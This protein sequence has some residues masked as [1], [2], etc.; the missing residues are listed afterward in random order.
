MRIE[1]FLEPADI[2]DLRREMDT[3]GAGFGILCLMAAFVLGANAYFLMWRDMNL[4][5]FLLIHL[6]TVGLLGIVAYAQFKNDADA[7]YPTFL[8]LA[9]CFCGVFGAAG[10]FISWLMGTVFNRYSHSFS[11]W[12]QTIFPRPVPRLPEEI[13]HNIMTG[14]DESPKRYSVIPFL[15][16]M[17]VGSEDQ[18]REALSKMTSMFDPSFAPA[19]QRALADP[20]NA[21]RVQAAT[22]ISRIENAYLGRSIQI[23]EAARQYP[24]DSNII[25]A[26]AQHYDEYA[27]TGLLDEEY[28]RA[29]R[30]KALRAYEKYIRIKPNDTNVRTQIGRILVR[31]EQFQKA[32]EWFRQCLADGH[33]NSS[34]IAWYLE[35]LYRLGEY[36]ELRKAAE[37]YQGHLVDRNVLQSGVMDAIRLWSPLSWAEVI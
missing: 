26:T 15:D 31:S 19:F 24:E 34:I 18:K 25:L 13:Y 28:E 16:V 37:K 30:Q 29:N 22:S 8:A 3:A 12:Y 36:D 9:S 6:A 20:S 17:A 32:A 21:I 14:R 4:F 11:D 10:T 27:F 2:H 33:E 1:S 5:L 7:R 23:E 35:C